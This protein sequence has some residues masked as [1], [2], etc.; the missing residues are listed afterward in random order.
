MGEPDVYLL[1]SKVS[2]YACLEVVFFTIDSAVR[3]LHCWNLGRECCL[4]IYPEINVFGMLMT[5]NYIMCDNR[6]SNLYGMIYRLGPSD[7]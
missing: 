3:A 5:L 1:C 4:S 2:R 6:Y 7:A